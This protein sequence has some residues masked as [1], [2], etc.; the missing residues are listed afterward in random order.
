MIEN[1]AFHSHNFM[2]YIFMK[3]II[4]I[5]L[6]VLLLILNSKQYLN[7]IPSTLFRPQYPPTHAL[8]SNQIYV[9][10]VNTRKLYSHANLM[11]DLLL[12]FTVALGG[13]FNSCIRCC[14]GVFVTVALGVVL[15][16]FTVA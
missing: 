4:C 3:K 15:V 13:F 9:R 10:A 1:K 12:F 7:L 11:F 6:L 16:F 5:T 14:F 8:I 2:N